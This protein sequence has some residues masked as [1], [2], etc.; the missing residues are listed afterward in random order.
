MRDPGGGGR[1]HEARRRLQLSGYRGNP[2]LGAP[3]SAVRTRTPPVGW[4]GV[5]GALSKDPEE[6]P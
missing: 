4:A 2:C 1:G 5:W 3:T 6:G